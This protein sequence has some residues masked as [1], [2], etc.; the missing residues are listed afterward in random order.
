M[1]K[2]MPVMS[3]HWKV[4]RLQMITMTINELKIFFRIFD[5]RLIQN[6]RKTYYKH[7]TLN[8]LMSKCIEP[9]YRTILSRLFN[10][11][12]CTVDLTWLN[13]FD[14][15]ILV[16]RTDRSYCNVTYNLAIVLVRRR[17]VA[18]WKDLVLV[19]LR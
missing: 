14:L 12:K 7:I 6:T 16:G 5:W 13:C 2:I 10:R 15:R 18:R 4:R 3:S 8:I 17:L 1:Q 9:N 19:R 11:I